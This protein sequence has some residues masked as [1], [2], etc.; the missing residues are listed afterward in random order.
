[1]PNYLACNIHN[2]ND[3]INGVGSDTLQATPQEIHEG[4]ETGYKIGMLDT[5]MVI[6]WE[7]RENEEP[8]ENNMT[9][10]LGLP[11]EYGEESY[12]PP[13]VPTEPIFE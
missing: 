13:T 9:A 4:A 3:F 11:T 10:N 5:Q 2:E 7:Q 1:M 8:G 6:Y 12:I